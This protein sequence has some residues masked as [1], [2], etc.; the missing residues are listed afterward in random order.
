MQTLNFQGVG[1]GGVT[2]NII[3]GHTET[4]SDPLVGTITQ[5]VQHTNQI[6]FQ[7]TGVGINPLITAALNG[8]TTNVMVL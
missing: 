2:F 6:I 4:F 1:S 7:K 8:T 3:A 5:Q